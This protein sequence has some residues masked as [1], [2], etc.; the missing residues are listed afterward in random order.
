[1]SCGVL[2]HHGE[3]VESMYLGIDFGTSGARAI[4]LHR[5]RTILAEVSRTF[6]A[7]APAQRPTVWQ[8]TLFELI[9]QIPADVRSHLRRIAVNGTSATVLLCNRQGQ[10]ICPPLM[11]NHACDQAIVGQVRAIA[12]S[13][14]PV[15]SASASLAKLL[16]WH[17]QGLTQPDYYFLH[18]ADW[19]AWLLHGKL[20]WS[21]YHNSLKLGYDPALGRYPNWFEHPRLQPLQPLLPQVVAPGTVLGTVAGAIAQSLAIPSNCQ[22]CAGTTDS[23]AAFLAS[24]AS[25][26]GDA[27]TSLGSTLVIKL[28]SPTRVDNADYGI[29]SHRLGNLWLAGGA[30]NTG[31][32][33]L[34]Q[35]FTAAELVELSDRIDPQQPSPLDYYPLLKPGERFPLNDPHLTPQ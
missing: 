34:K 31:G 23:I 12:P 29:Y 2:G 3:A 24:G 20:G 28:L 15:T 6:E 1:M 18:Q 32:A 9:Q 13:G 5:D 11:Y 30:S 27:V 25:Q 19:L 14:H 10:P 7:I 33:V 16:Q 35:Y 21:D 26:P 4:A 17:Q 8:L 22:I